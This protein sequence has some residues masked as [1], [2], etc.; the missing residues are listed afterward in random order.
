M[1]VFSGKYRK[2]Q[3]SSNNPKAFG[4]LSNLQQVEI[5][6]Q[7]KDGAL[8]FGNEKATY[9]SKAQED[10]LLFDDVK[11][12]IVLPPGKSQLRMDIAYEY[13]DATYTLYVRN[14]KTGLIKSINGIFHSKTPSNTEYFVF[15][16]DKWQ[17]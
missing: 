3:F 13:F 7:K 12:A 15:V 10:R 4:Y 14:N 8:L 2:I 6:I 16:N 17:R 11:Q 5:P 9:L 1:S